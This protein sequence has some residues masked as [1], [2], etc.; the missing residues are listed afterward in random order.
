MWSLASDP[1]T[2]L[3]DSQMLDGDPTAVDRIP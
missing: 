2:C 3:V 1:L